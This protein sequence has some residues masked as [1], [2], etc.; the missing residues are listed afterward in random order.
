[1]TPELIEP[2]LWRIPLTMP[3]GPEFVNVYL[4]R[5]ADG[6]ILID[7]GMGFPA[8]FEELAVALA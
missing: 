5:A 8:V 4:L 1:M 7:T 3:V 2:G 6:W